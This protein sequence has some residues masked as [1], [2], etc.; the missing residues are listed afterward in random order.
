MGLGALALLIAIWGRI[1]DYRRW[2]CGFYIMAISLIMLFLAEVL[3][4]GLQQLRYSERDDK[5]DLWDDL[6]TTGEK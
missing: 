1:A 3:V 2:Q 5:T 6:S 4:V